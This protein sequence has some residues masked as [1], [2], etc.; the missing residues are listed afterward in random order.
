MSSARDFGITVVRTSGA[1]ENVIC[2]FHADSSPSASFNKTKGLFYCYVCGVGYN[3]S[4]LAEKL[5]IDMGDLDDEMEVLSD[6]DFVSGDTPLEIGE[7]VEWHKYYWERKVSGITCFTYDLHF[8]EGSFPAAVF[9]VKSLKGEVIGAVYRFTDPK[10]NRY[11]KVGQM[12][13]VWPMPFLKT[14]REGQPVIVCEGV[15][16]ALRI[17][18]FFSD[19]HSH[20]AALCLFGAKANQ[21]IIDTLNPF[22][23]VYLYDHD[24]AGIKA[25]K[26]M[27][28]LSPTSLAFT[29]STA[30]DD[31]TDEQL[32][33]L[34]V[35]ITSEVMK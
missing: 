32:E 13:P 3:I 33:D 30:P 16:S 2:P 26:K 15:F 7:R 8:K 1:E 18:S 22:R 5:C 29:L 9:P 21:Q 6:Y 24:Q 25:C 19:I 10:G 34:F 12:T 4:Q 17:H 14:F 31:M 20:L 23:P 35:K 27:R 11:V 28:Q